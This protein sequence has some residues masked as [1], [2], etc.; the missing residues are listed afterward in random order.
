MNVLTVWVEIGI[1]TVVIDINIIISI[2]S[3]IDITINIV[4]EIIIGEIEIVGAIVSM[5]GHS[6]WFR[7]G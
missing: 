5:I 1:K 6:L 2:D 4:G 3:I 7:K